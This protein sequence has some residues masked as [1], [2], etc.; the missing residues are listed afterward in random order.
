MVIIEKIQNTEYPRVLVLSH[1]CF[2]KSGSNGRTLSNLFHKWPEQSIAQFYISNEIPDFDVCKN[3]FNVT[4]KE[5]FNSFFKGSKAGKVREEENLIN[6]KPSINNVPSRFKRKSSFNYLARNL[7]WDSNRWKSKDFE[8][9]INNFQPN[10]ILIQLGDYSFMLRIALK[11]AQLREIPLII[12]NSEDYYFKNKKTFSI[13]YHLFNID[14]KRQ[15][16]KL[17]NY[18]ST[19][20][21]ISEMLQKTYQS[22]FN[23]NSSVIMNSTEIKS[24]KKK[25]NNDI[26]KVS[27]LGNLGLGRHEPLIEIA[28]TLNRLDSNVFLEIYGKT[29]SDEV[30]DALNSCRGIRLKGLISYDEVV[31]VME[32]SDIL[33][34]AENFS[35]F[36]QKDLTHAFSTKIADS[37][38]SA[39][40]LI[41]APKNMGF[42]KYINENNAACI[43][44]SS[45]ELKIKLEELIQ[46][47]DLRQY[48]FDNG[49]KLAQK[50]H[51]KDVNSNKFKQIILESTMKG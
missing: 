14:Y 45:N 48:Y 18:S 1:N 44:N 15:V 25:K 38:V 35:D 33:V 19:S 50:L 43:I 8:E 40:F 42:L 49:I 20:I 46:N 17:I 34:H 36:Y 22:E 10:V 11:I 12:Y 37:L 13:L 3:Y 7:I 39:C 24:T 6:K 2:S 47:K 28:N 27:Y 21:Y 16:K 23:H 32:S 4:D 26:L 9:W 29:P 30:A 31:K 51:N 5:V 41:F